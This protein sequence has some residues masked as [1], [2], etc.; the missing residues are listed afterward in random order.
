L[1]DAAGTAAASR[2]PRDAGLRASR[3]A[4]TTARVA[5][6]PTM[7]INPIT[8]S[9]GASV[10][11]LRPTAMTVPATST[12]GVNGNRSGMNGTRSKYSRRCAIRPLRAVRKTT[13]SCR[14]TFHWADT[15]SSCYLYLI[16]MRGGALAVRRRFHSLTH[17]M[18]NP[19]SL[20]KV[21]VR[22]LLCRW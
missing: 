17:V 22:I 15:W 3:A 13:Y 6:A 20:Y 11:T 9:P 12:P 8:S 1:S 19:F 2:K 16:A 4:S 10:V 7:P 18:S 5:K 14:S 21:P